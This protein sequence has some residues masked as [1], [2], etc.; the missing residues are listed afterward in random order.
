MPVVGG[1][2]VLYS[3]FANFILIMVKMLGKWFNRKYFYWEIRS[4]SCILIILFE[5]DD[6]AVFISYWF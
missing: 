3:F 4:S 5:K 1:K 6:D 2:C